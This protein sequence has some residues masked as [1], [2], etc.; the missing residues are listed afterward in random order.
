M[1]R[2]LTL[3]VPSLTFGG[4]EHVVAQMAN[5]WAAR[6]EDVTVITL[7]ARR[8][9]TYRLESS[10]KRIALDV[11]IESRGSIQ[12]IANNLVRVRKLRAAIDRS[13]PEIV[14]SF[15]DQMNVLTLLACRPL[16]IDT[17]ISERIDPSRQAI[18][19]AWSI[20]RRRTYPAARALVVQTERVR[21][22]MIPVMRGRP[23]YV[24]PNS[25]Q[26]PL[27]EAEK[28]HR[29]DSTACARQ[30][31]GMGRLAPQKGFD[32]LIDAFARIAE[33]FP[34]W[35]LTILGE[36]P[37]RPALEQ[38]VVLR[39]LQ[40]RIRLPG[41]EPEPITVLRQSELF[42][43][44][45]RFEGFPNALLEAMAAGLAVISFDCPSGPAEIIHDGID[46]ILV[47]PENVTA[48]ASAIE[49]VLADEPLRRRLAIEAVRVVDRFS[50]DRYYTRWDAVLQGAP[51]ESGG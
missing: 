28:L 44:S 16:N 26:A 43:L 23:I 31:V 9:D 27:E 45:S 25:V 34:Q 11:Q 12:A 38:L 19:R 20:L 8:C 5:H 7:S 46:G 6:G 24:I 17:V 50:V 10:V 41:W 18:G 39:R 35:S 22:Q 30:I 2:R 13:A 14:I 48:L 15:T 42:V 29:P 3:V 32:L 1:G 40:D 21:Q 37:Q 49:R 33:Q 4:A 36:G 47:P 51:P